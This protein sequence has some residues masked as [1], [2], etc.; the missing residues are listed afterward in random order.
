[1]A[2]S[3]FLKIDGIEGESTDAAHKG[4]IDVQA[5]SWG[6][7]QTG[8]APGSGGG[9]GKADFQDFHFVARISKASPQLF[10][11]CATSTHHKV[12]A[13]SGVRSAG[14]SKAADFLKYKLSDVQVTSVQHSDGE[15]GPPMEQ[16]SLNY[17]KFEISYSPQTATGQL[18]PAVVAGFDL[19]QN[20]K[21]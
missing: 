9:S 5:W 6:V 3:W 18:G 12:A 4:E 21:I 16:F 15:S 8:G 1:V 17:S 11:A 19:K 10:L 2:E 14:K 7:S 13:L 20:K